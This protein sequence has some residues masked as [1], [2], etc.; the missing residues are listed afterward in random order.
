VALPD[1]L[2]D[3]M[4]KHI[5]SIFGQNGVHSAV[6]LA[7]QVDPT[8][9][10]F[11]VGQ[12]AELPQVALTRELVNLLGRKVAVTTLSNVWEE[13]GLARLDAMVWAD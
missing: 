10:C 6:Y 9:A 11:V 8:E 13:V 2:D 5:T 4:C 12:V 3:D 7:K 1:W